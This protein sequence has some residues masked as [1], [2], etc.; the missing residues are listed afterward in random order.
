[1]GKFQ[2]R[3][4]LGKSYMSTASTNITN[5][6]FGGKSKDDIFDDFICELFSSKAGAQLDLSGSRSMLLLKSEKR[7]H[8]VNPNQTLPMD[9]SLLI[10]TAKK[11]NMQMLLNNLS[12]SADSGS[13]G[14][15]SHQE[16]RN[17]ALKLTSELQNS[18]RLA[19][20]ANLSVIN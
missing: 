9:Q 15:I 4:A 17:A 5:I 1:M 20:M 19:N 16:I 13:A 7:D 10:S 8:R 3:G 2:P 11:Q 12:A 18:A 14:L 6:T